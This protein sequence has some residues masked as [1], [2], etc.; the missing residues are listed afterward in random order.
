M[1]DEKAHPGMQGIAGSV[2]AQEPG[3]VLLELFDLAAID[4]LNDGMAGG[5]MAI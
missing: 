4:G 2:F 3:S 5:K 1:V